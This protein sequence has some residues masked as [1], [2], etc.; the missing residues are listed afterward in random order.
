MSETKAM[1][2]SICLA[3][4]TINLLQTQSSY[5]QLY[6]ETEYEMGAIKSYMGQENIE[7]LAQ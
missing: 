7:G 4:S 6:A 3:M 5:M 1:S 2:P